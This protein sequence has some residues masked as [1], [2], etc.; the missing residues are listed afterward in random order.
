MQT[1]S[2]RTLFPRHDARSNRL[3]TGTMQQAPHACMVFDEIIQPFTPA[4]AAHHAQRA[5]NLQSLHAFLA[6]GVIEAHYDWQKVQLP[7]LGSALIISRQPSVFASTCYVSIRATPRH[8]QI[9]HCGTQATVPVQGIR[10]YLASAW[11]L[12]EGLSYVHDG[13][14]RTKSSTS[15]MSK[16]LTS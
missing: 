3:R 10:S 11:E 8:G 6:H 7:V 9:T 16:R 2:S 5:G 15:W 1:S 4:T 14:V 12:W 13:D